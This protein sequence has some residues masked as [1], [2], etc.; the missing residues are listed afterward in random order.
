M[1]AL[2][3]GKSIWGEMLFFRN[4]AKPSLFNIYADDEKEI[5]LSPN[6]KSKMKKTILTLTNVLK[7]KKKK[8]QML[9]RLEEPIIFS[10]PD[11][12]WTPWNHKNKS[13]M[14]STKI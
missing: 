11:C 5:S 1:Y 14:C 2:N 4:F 12:Q 3:G 9:K 6:E 8:I 7:E 10:C 13:D